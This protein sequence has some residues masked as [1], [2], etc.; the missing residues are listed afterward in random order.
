ME[1]AN[2]KEFQSKLFDALLW[3]SDTKEIDNVVDVFLREVSMYYNFE[4]GGIFFPAGDLLI[5]R[6]VFG[7]DRYFVC[8]VAYKM[9]SN[10]ANILL[11]NKEKYVGRNINI[12]HWDV[13]NQFETMFA[14]PIHVCSTVIGIFITRSRIDKTEYFREIL[15]EIDILV[16]HFAIYANN[17]L[18]KVEYGDKEQHIMLLNEIA[19][20][21]AIS[22][23]LKEPLD[24]LAQDLTQVFS[25]KK[26]I[27]ALFDDN[28]HVY[29][30]SVWGLNDD[31]IIN[32]PFI[33]NYKEDEIPSFINGIEYIEE[34]RDYR[35]CVE[36]SIMILPLK[37]DGITL[38]VVAIIDKI[39]SATNPLGDFLSGDEHL[40]RNTAS[41]IAANI[42]QYN[43][44]RL[45]NSATQRN[46]I[47]TNRLN[48]LYEL[49]NSLL[50]KLKIND[51]L[52][53][54]L[55]ATTLGE[56]FGYN[57]SFAFLYDEKTNTFTGSMCIAPV[58]GNDAANVWHALETNT[59]TSV[60]EKLLLLFTE[61]DLKNINSLT[62]KIQKL[63]IPAD[64]SCTIFNDIYT[65]KKSI[66]IQDINDNELVKQIRN[67]TDIFA[68]TPFAVVP[69]I[70][71][72]SCIGLIVIDNHFT[73]EPI[74]DDDLNYIKM[75]AQQISIAIEYSRLYD[76]IEQSSLELRNTQDKLTEASHLALIGEM[77]TSI[78][79]NLRNFIVPITGF[80]NRLK[81]VKNVDKEVEKYVNIIYEEMIRLEQY[82]KSNLSFAK[83]VKLNVE[84][85]P[86]T[87]IENTMKTMSI[88]CIIQSKKNIEFTMVCNKKNILVRW[89][90]MK[91]HEVFLN[92][93]LNAVDAV[94]ADKKSYITCIIEI[95]SYDDKLLDIHIKNSHSYINKKIIKE[96]FDPFFTTKSHGSGLGLPSSLRI[97]E[98]HYGSI[99]VDTSA[100]PKYTDFI[101]TIPIVVS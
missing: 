89:D 71:S 88:E 101:I 76:S 74:D 3:A 69:M 6:G 39:P 99:H 24:N 96:I 2:F 34:Y 57:R 91:M 82:V 30:R 56:S 20:N 51:I 78:S 38:G 40:F 14:V 17:I 15:D 97:I 80:A 65:N 62:R 18:Q 37:A 1:R 7:L 61:R 94:P 33:Q 68:N 23:D 77:S 32:M 36:H 60:R 46:E 55:T 31:V 44:L 73:N 47:N 48:I 63:S 66:V 86:M 26:A 21:F 25:V 5:L 54:L 4:T 11:V 100:S 29:L 84:D 12:S 72:S 45:L 79:H 8:K 50:G 52:F 19:V 49:S 42:N 98:A 22:K 13:F 75:F 95:N 9:D 10:I 16:R 27:V 90:Y 58:D 85:V 70:G 92:L 53:I 93:L 83:T 41:H 81:R 59:N 43:T 67:Y 64:N 28:N 87:S 35:I